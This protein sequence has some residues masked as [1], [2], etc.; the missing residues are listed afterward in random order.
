M[1]LAS[2]KLNA[3]SEILGERV[4]PLRVI[5]TLTQVLPD[6]AAVQALQLVGTKVSLSGQA[7]DAAELMQKLGQQPGIR[8]VRAP[9]AAT[10]LNNSNK[11]SFS[12]EF[13]VDPKVFG[14]SGPQTPV[15]GAVPV[16]GSAVAPAA[17]A[18][19]AAS[20]GGGRR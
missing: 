10:R 15:A 11:E 4:E 20:G 12:I 18:A 17:P 14:A 7:T 8:D 16:A 1:V 5:D 2:N 19:S 6:D 9:A 3:L 13:V